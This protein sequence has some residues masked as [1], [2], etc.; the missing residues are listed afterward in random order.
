MLNRRNLLMG[1]PAAALMTQQARP[2]MA[3]SQPAGSP[4]VPDKKG[5]ML[6]NR[7]GPSSSDLHI[8]NADG[9]GE[10]KFLPNAAFE[11]NASF[12]P[13]GKGVVFTSERNG[14]GQSDVLFAN[15]DGTGIESL[16]ADPAVDDAA[17]LSPDGTRLAFVSTRNGYRA[18][19]WVADLRVR[20][21][22]DIT[23][24]ADVQGDPAGPN[25]FFRPSWSPDGQWLAFSSDRN[26]DWRGHSGGHGWE[27][28][29]ELSVYVIRADGGGFRRIA[30]KPGYSLGSPKWSPDGRRIVF[31]EMTTEDTWGAR[32]PNLVAKVV[33]QIVS[34]DV[35][36]GERVEHTSGSGLK[37][38]PQFLSATEIAY[39]R[40]GGPDEGLYYTSGPPAFKAVLRSPSWSPDGR[41]VIYEKNDFRPRPENQRL[42]SW[43]PEW[44]YRHSDVFPALSRDGR[45]VF[46]EKAKSSSIV[47]MNPDGSNRRRIYDADTSGLDPAMVQRGMAGAFQPSWSPDGQWV[48][49]GLGEWFQAR[50][51]GNARI[52]R[53]RQDGTGL[54]ALTDGKVHSGFPSYSA[55]G[56]QIVYRVWGESQKQYGLRILN[57]EDRTTRVLTTE[58]DN[59]PGWSPDGSRILF[60]RRLD[61]VNFD[62]FTIKPDGSDLL[63]LTTNRATDGHAVWTWDGRILWN[64]GMY[65][66]RDE[67][68]LY[69]NTFQQ[70]GQIFVMN[71]DG[72]GKRMLTDSRWEDSMP[73]YIPAK[74]L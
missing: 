33:S 26:T 8:A 18:N 25:G 27:H 58:A 74:F 21:L 61:T 57:L 63:R 67:A 17:V 66:F 60:T 16:V 22:C 69:D 30:S 3:Q 5:V 55:D 59:L 4:L 32:R 7:I 36:T 42:Y 12:A 52:M 37:V 56:R 68:A 71:A 29:Q 46:T 62:V 50:R 72:S 44:V 40:K 41:M 28:T 11:Y 24:A 9:S 19:I 31:Y 65:G 47:I 38:F 53:I 73:L 34:V 1:L 14:A 64:S 6:M 35:A 23:G 20:A 43:D 49:F 48:A 10:R 54:E 2:V 45:L 70:Y 51:S 39:H 13:D 15:L